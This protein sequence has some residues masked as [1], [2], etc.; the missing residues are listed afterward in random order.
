MEA[1]KASHSVARMADLLTVSRSG[2]YAWTKREQAGPSPAQQRRAQL[3]TKITKF[4]HES[5]QVYGSPRIFADL[6]EDGEQV[7]RKTVAK[8]MRS[9][10]IVGISPR[11]WTPTT[12]VPDLA[13]APIPDLVGRRFDPAG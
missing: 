10:G 12:T 4:H 11:G 3:T 1:E 8:L 6:R 13:A 2:Y 7:S 9:N 5:D